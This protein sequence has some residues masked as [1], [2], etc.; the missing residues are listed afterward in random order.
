VPLIAAG[1]LTIE[2]VFPYVLGA[3][4][5]TT[6]TA[7]LASLATGSVVAVTVA[8]A[9]LCFN[10]SG[11]LIWYP[12]RRLPIAMALKMAEICTRSRKLALVYLVVVFYVIPGLLILIAR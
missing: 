12:F 11:T 6:I 3:N 9:H 2:Q 5:G 7:M 4:L 1:L 10:I 8:F